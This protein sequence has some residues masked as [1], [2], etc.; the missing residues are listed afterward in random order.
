MAKILVTG[1]AGYIGGVCVEKLITKGHEVVIVDSLE[2]GHKENVNKKATFYQGRVGDKKLMDK[3]FKE[4]EIRMVFHF[5]GLIQVGESV[6]EPGKYFDSNLVQGISLLDSMRKNDVLKIVF[7]S[8][9]A[10][11]G[12]PKRVPIEEDDVKKPINPYGE[13]KWMFEQVLNRYHLAYGLKYHAFRYFNA[14]GATTKNKEKHEPETHLIPLIMQAAR[15][16]REAISVFGSDYDTPDGTCVR[17]YVHVSDIVNAHLLSMNT[18]DEYPAKAFNL[19]NGNGYSVKEVIEM[20][21]KVS[22]KEFKIIEAERREGDP[23]R[24]VASS[25]RAK[26]LLG[27]KAKY[28]ELEGIV[29]SAW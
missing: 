12:T 23:A 13:A 18:L 28:P 21:K 22:G 2:T 1:G 11:Y 8:T 4:N 19:G 6:K 14:A 20:V 27:F 29:K 16:E 17:D 24:L 9:A 26:E 7:S 10:V 25:K 5:A 3:V 15:G